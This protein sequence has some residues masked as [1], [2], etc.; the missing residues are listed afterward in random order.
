MVLHV[1]TKLVTDITHKA[2]LEHPTLMEK[3]LRQA[4]GMRQ[5]QNHWPWGTSEYV[6]YSTLQFP[7]HYFRNRNGN[8]IKRNV[9]ISFEIRYAGLHNCIK[10]DYL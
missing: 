10:A 6:Y 2:D 8:Y 1:I 3:L 7:A 4:A 9:W 5:S